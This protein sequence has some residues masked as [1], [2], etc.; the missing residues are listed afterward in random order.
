V[1]ILGFAYVMGRAV[2]ALGQPRIIGE[3]VAGIALGPSVL[4]T[5]AHGTMQALFPADRM[6]PLAT[7]SQ[8]GVILFVFV[9]GLRFD[10]G[11]LKGRVRSAVVVSHASILVPFLLG[12]LLGHWLYPG[13]AGTAVARLPFVLFCGAA[14]SV[15]AFPV[16]AKILSE[17]AL[18]NTRLGSMAIACAAVDDVTAWCLLAGIV[19]IARHQGELTLFGLTIGGAAAYTVL[20]STAGR[21]LLLRAWTV[22]RRH[23]PSAALDHHLVGVA[24]LIALASALATEWLGIHPLFGAFLAGSVIP[25]EARLA[26]IIADKIDSLIEAVLLPVFFVFT[27]LH[28]EV[29]LITG[30]GSWGIFAVLLAAAVTGKLAGSAGASRLMGM[31]WADSL[32]LG[33]LMNTRGLMELV[34]LNVGLEIGVIGRELFTMMVLMAIVTTVMTSPLLALVLRLEYPRHD[35]DAATR[36]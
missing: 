25:R 3:M 12:S 35:A 11:L 29:G 21:R 36:L 7:L 8:V 18:V 2:G 31:S 22:G 30:A 19:A 6:V 9:V 28:T 32:A 23:S 1:V 26:G 17:R 20:V 5:V 34:I 15:T 24:V 27:G 14:M 10:L 4:G 13:M 33:V 16:L